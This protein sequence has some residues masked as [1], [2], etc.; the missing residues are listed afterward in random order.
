MEADAEVMVLA[1]AAT[2]LGLFTTSQATEV[3]L[4]R[5]TRRTRVAQKIWRR[6]YWNVYFVEGHPM[7]PAAEHLAA[8]LA[9]GVTARAS[10]R[11][12]AWLWGMTAYPQKPEITV[13][14]Q[15]PR[16]PDVRIHRTRTLLLPPTVRQGVPVTSA[17]ET[18]LDLGGVVSLAKVQSALDRGIANRVLTPMAALAE[19]ERRG[20]IG[21][22][23]TAH[24]RKLLDDAGVTGSHHPSVLEAKTRRL[25]KKAGLPQPECELVVGKNGE[26]RLDFS[27]PKLMLA[28]EVDGWMYHSS[29]DAFHGNKTRKNSLTIEGYSILEYTW[30]HVTR[31]PTTVVREMRAA[32]GAR[33]SLLVV[34]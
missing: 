15:Q 2:Q 12:G 6:V 19:L 27:W 23:G 30:M 3:G 25:V 32:Y 17:A 7:T 1:I 14:G 11:A 13:V 4:S 28:V 33:S 34:P 10:H 18:L 26:Y 20:K 29:Q 8:V 16:I 5:E 22:R 31:T 21:V 9:G 24:L